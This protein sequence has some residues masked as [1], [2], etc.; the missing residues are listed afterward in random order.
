MRLKAR[1][2]LIGHKTRSMLDRYNV[3]VERDLTEAG[4]KLM[5]TFMGT[6]GAFDLDPRCINV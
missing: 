2:A 3:V 5:G 6:I 4:R 1:M